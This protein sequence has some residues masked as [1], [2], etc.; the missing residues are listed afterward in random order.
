MSAAAPPFRPRPLRKYAAFSRLAFRR[1]LAD[2]APVLGRA[3]FLLVILVIFSRLFAFVAESGALPG[4]GLRELVWYVAV[5]EWIT[6]SL[7]WVFLEVE[8]DVKT[9]DVA[10]HLPRPASYLG[11]V[12]ARGGGEYAA[13]LLALAPAAAL[14][15]ALVAGGLPDDARGLALALPLGL[16]GAVLG[17]VASAAIGL[18]A[19]WLGDTSPVYWIW[20]KLSFVL[21]G[22]LLPLEIYPAWLREVAWASPFAPMLWGPGAMAFGLDVSL[23]AEVALRQ[24]LW[25]LVALGF[26]LWLYRRALRAL[27]VGGG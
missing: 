9:G 13:R 23:A 22:L 17:L 6:L 25:S 24:A 7:P 10:C 21:G 3:G 19:V 20:Q 4:L 26:V 15:A 18:S 14:F 27:T 2:R 8:N 1:T 12:L 5:T 11:V 16:G